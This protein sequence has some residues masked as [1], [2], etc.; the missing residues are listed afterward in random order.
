MTTGR[1]TAATLSVRSSMPA[2]SARISRHC[3]R[4]AGL[5]PAR[6]S[7]PLT[8]TFGN[9]C[10]P[11][12][13]LA[14]AGSEVHHE[15]LVE[16]FRGCG[17][18]RLEPGHDLH[19]RRAWGTAKRARQRKARHSHSAGLDRCLAG[20]TRAGCSRSQTHRCFAERSGVMNAGD[21]DGT[22]SDARDDARACRTRGRRAAGS[23]SRHAAC[24]APQG[25][26]SAFPSA[27]AFRSVS[28][29]R[30]RGLRSGER[31]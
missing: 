12:G 10:Q 9:S 22:S 31:S 27:R 7:A 28:A 25:E 20:T 21:G 18:R 11:A 15:A 29:V 16:C 23:V 26:G 2:T 14:K 8:W 13:A 5:R 24:V 3:S 6:Q 1:A 19:G 30:R 17:V 4:R